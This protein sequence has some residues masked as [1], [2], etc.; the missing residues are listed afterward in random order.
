MKYIIETGKWMLVPVFFVI[1]IPVMLFAFFTGLA[2]V[3][4]HG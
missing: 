2:G 3:D 1:A 4:G